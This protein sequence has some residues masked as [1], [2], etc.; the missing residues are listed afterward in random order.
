MTADSSLIAAPSIPGYE[1][2]GELGRGAMGVVYRAKQTALGRIVALKMI[3]PREKVRDTDLAR[4]QTEAE[5]AA[6]LQHPNVAQLY[7]IGQH[8][9]LPYIAMEFCPGGTLADQLQDS[10]MPARESAELV[11]TLANAV[12]AAHELGILHRDLKPANVLLARS[13]LISDSQ[14]TLRDTQTETKEMRK[15]AGHSTSHDSSSLVPKIT[16]FGMAKKFDPGTGEAASNL[17]HAGT[18]IGTPS[19]MSPEQSDGNS[20][21]LSDVYSL[22]AILYHCLTGRPPFKGATAL[23]TLM[24]LLDKEPVPPSKLVAKVPP[25]L[26]A[27]CLK[28]LEKSPAKRYDSAAALA[29]DLDRFISGL[30]TVARPLSR[31]AQLIKWAKRRP[32]VAGLVG[33]G[34]LSLIVFACLSVGLW[35]ALHEAA[36]QRD[37]AV[38]TS[39]VAMAAIDDILQQ[40]DLPGS[41]DPEVQRQAM[42]DSVS[43][44]LM[45]LAEYGGVDRELLDRSVKAY[46]RRG[47]LLVDVA[48][49]DEAVAAYQQ[50]I[51]LAQKQ[52][53]AQP[54][55]LEWRRELATAKNRIAG[56]FDRKGDV[57]RATV[58]YQEAEDLRRALVNETHAAEDEHDL[59]VT[60]YNRAGM[61]AELAGKPVEASKRFDESCTLLKNVVAQKPD[62]LKYR[63]SLAQCWFNLG[64][65]LSHDPAKS[66]ES[67][68]AFQKAKAHWTDLVKRAS[69]S[70]LY[71]TKLA[72]CLTE[73]GR[74]F[75]DQHLTSEALAQYREALVVYRDMSKRH[76]KVATYQGMLGLTS[77][78]LG[79]LEDEQNPREERMLLLQEAV[80]A[81]TNA[82]GLP[83]FRE[84]MANALLALARA[85]K[86]AGA[87]ESHRTFDQA[88]ARYEEVA[89][90]FPNNEEIRKNLETARRE[91]D[92]MK[93][94]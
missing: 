85:Q 55:D 41:G 79:Q 70:L 82:Q 53:A 35:R 51:D 93:E 62:Q 75:H 29:E 34:F 43:R 9:G 92:Q 5:A 76:P 52:L 16:D 91:R 11:R 15:T 6:A 90:Q 12:Q 26:E 8:D 57:A 17:T 50:A 24:D 44:S 18:I 58:A 84:P 54:N 69:E 47:R 61:D 30:P 31:S 89:Q 10:V 86:A 63:D 81:L 40:E 1:I 49:L 67:L 64:R 65:F 3:L 59:G 42:L 71:Q 74:L 32:A 68:S 56:A 4:F 66:N 22:G 87:A 33:V 37:R 73:L 14:Q 72:A 88:V 23:D 38:G 83:M 48:K 60:L 2:L 36:L 45:R 77:S 80:K 39:G 19:Y 21:P 27:I 7:E 25:D 13:R 46:L 28:C 78:N 94:A 20:S